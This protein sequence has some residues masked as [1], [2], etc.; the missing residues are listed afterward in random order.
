[1]R[2]RSTHFPKW[3]ET[4]NSSSDQSEKGNNFVC[5]NGATVKNNLF[6]RTKKKVEAEGR[7]KK[8]KKILMYFGVAFCFFPTT[9]SMERRKF[10]SFKVFLI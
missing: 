5:A 7:K 6:H 10:M 2:Q 1:M 4:N 8:L 9:L 3:L